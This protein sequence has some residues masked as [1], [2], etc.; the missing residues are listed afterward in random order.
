MRNFTYITIIFLLACCQNAQLDK[1]DIKNKKSGII[2]MKATGDAKI[3]M[4]K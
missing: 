2:I 3:N 4:K 1:E